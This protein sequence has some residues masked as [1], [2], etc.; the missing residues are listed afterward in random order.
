MGNEFSTNE[1][2]NEYIEDI[3]VIRRR[4]EPTREIKK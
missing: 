4:T 3:G 1:R 2:D